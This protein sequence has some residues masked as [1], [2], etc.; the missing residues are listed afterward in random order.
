MTPRRRLRVPRPGRQGRPGR[1]GLFGRAMAPTGTAD[2]T[3]ARSVRR[4]LPGGRSGTKCG[5]LSLPRMAESRGAATLRIT[6]RRQDWSHPSDSLRP[7]CASWN[8]DRRGWSDAQ[9]RPSSHSSVRSNCS[10]CIFR[11]NSW[12]S[13]S[14]KASICLSAA[15]FGPVPRDQRHEQSGN[16][17]RPVEHTRPAAR[18]RL[19]GAG[20]ES[21]RFTTC[22][23]RTQP[24][25]NRRR[26]GDRR[27]SRA[28]KTILRTL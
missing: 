22:P 10:G 17:A 18:G 20:I 23:C 11:S 5:S 14:S 8:S 19:P 7:A 16:H 12:R 2:R 28:S 26:A 3:V 15:Y 13:F 27:A 6:P 1:R 25:G 9:V 4:N 24:Q 21:G